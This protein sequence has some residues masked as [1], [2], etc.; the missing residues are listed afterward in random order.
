MEARIEEQDHP[1]LLWVAVVGAAGFMLGARTLGFGFV[2]DDFWTI[3]ENGYLK[4]PGALLGLADGTAA[5]LDVPDAGRPLIVVHHWIEWRLF[6]SGSSGYHL[7]SLLWHVGACVLAYLTVLE[8]LGSTRTAV[9]AGLLFAAHPIHAEV[10]AVISF[11]EDSMS[12]VFGLA[13]WYVLLRSSRLEGSKRALCAALS[14]SLF[15]GGMACKESVP[16]LLLA[17]P[18]AGSLCHGLSL[19]QEL[20]RSR[21]EYIALA[22]AVAVG[23]AFRWAVFGTLDPYR[24]PANP[25]PA[26]LWGAEGHVR[27][28]TAARM[29]MTGLGQLSSFGWGQSPE[30]CEWPASWSDPFSWF[31][32]VGTA[33]AVAAAWTVRKRCPASAAGLVFLCVAFAPTSDLFW[34][35]NLR[36]DRFWYLCS[37]GFCL[38][39]AELGLAAGRALSQTVRSEQLRAGLQWA[40]VAF[41]VTLWGIGLQVHLGTFQNDRRLWLEAGRKA[42]CHSRALSG[43]AVSHLYENRTATA[44]RLARRAI[45]IRPG[46]APAYQ[47]LG[48]V[49][50]QAGRPLSALEAFRFSCHY[51]FWKEAECRVGMARALLQIGQKKA[52][53]TALARALQVNPAGREARFISAELAMSEGKDDAAAQQLLL[54]IASGL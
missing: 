47:V 6:G 54:A 43:A 53:R 7:M 12:C 2:F 41:L 34:M 48:R 5:S 27:I 11:R 39:A 38:M 31:G 51:R 24:G 9:A 49:L 37:F 23:I 10:V 4:A 18:L 16:V 46:Y 1:D 20:A 26:D 45:E 21:W 25:H 40:G 52:A 32:L 50:L 44:E 33:G 15:L 30:Y 17:F 3:L 14:G 29:F 36:A 28:L 19:K 22:V 8:L 42:P 35:P 13:S